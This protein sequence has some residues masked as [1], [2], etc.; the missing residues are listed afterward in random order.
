MNS[1]RPRFTYRE[2]MLFSICILVIAGIL[3]VVVNSCQA[4]ITPTPTRPP[5]TLIPPIT[6]APP[7][8]T[9]TPTFTATVPPTATSTTTPT[10]TATKRPSVTPDMGRTPEPA[11]TAGCWLRLPRDKDIGETEDQWVVIYYPCYPQRS[12]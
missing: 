1:G 10:S 2:W 4:R 12:P 11:S 9:P 5:I 3:G 6:V 8:K 7:T